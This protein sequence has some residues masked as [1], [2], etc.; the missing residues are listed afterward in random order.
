M[1]LSLYIRGRR[2][3][4]PLDMGRRLVGPQ[5]WSYI[6]GNRTQA[7]QPIALHYT[8]LFRALMEEGMDIQIYYMYLGLQRIPQNICQYLYT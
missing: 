2:L 7:V 4:Y 5:S 3:S 6:D 8:E 1:T